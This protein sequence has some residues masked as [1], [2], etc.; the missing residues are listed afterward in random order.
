MPRSRRIIPDN[1]ALHVISRGNNKQIVFHADN[2][3]LRYY[4]L[5]RDLKEEN[6]ISIFHYCLMDNHVHLLLG[7]NEKS[8]VSKFMKQVN[9][10][11]FYYYRKLY[12]YAG[13]FWQ[14]RFRSNIIEADFHLLQCAKYIELNPVRAGMVGHPSDYLFSSYNFYARGKEDTLIANSPVYLNLS[15][16]AVS[17]QKQ[18][19][20]F[21]VDTSIINSN[22]LMKKFYIGSQAFIDRSQQYYNLRERRDNRGRP[23]KEE[24]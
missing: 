2:D 12:G 10:S 17:R 1:A 7:L 22:M 6:K 11:Y 5:L 16:S 13:H 19:V 15:D 3:K 14:N 20:D 9:L 21:V 24:K 4:A 8:S 23:P 18:Y